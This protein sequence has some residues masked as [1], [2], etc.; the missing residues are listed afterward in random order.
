MAHVLI[1]DDE[2]ELCRLLDTLLRERG[3]D[4]ES[5]HSG[6]AAIAA[7]SERQPELVLLDMRL[8]GMD[9][10]ETLRRLR[11]HAP[12]TPIVIM[13]AFGNVQAAVEA[14]KLGATDFISKP[15][16]NLA[17]LAT[18]ETLLTMRRESR[19]QA[20]ELVGDSPAFRHT[21]SLAL[22]FAVP[23]INVLLLGET[24]TGKELFARTIHAASK[25]RAGPF[26]PVDCSMLAENLIESELFG[27]EKGAFTGATG[28][29][30]GRFE[31]AQEGTL[32]LDEIGNL[33][34]QFQ[35]KLLRVLQERRLERVGGRASI[36][37]DVRVVSATNVDMCA[38]LERGRFR[39][40]LYYRLQGMT[41][42]LPPLRERE[43]DIQAIAEHFVR[44]YAA[45]FGRN[46]QGISEAALELLERY[47]WP[48][49]VRELENSMKSAVVLATDL[50]LPEHLPPDVRHGGPQAGPV[51][52]VRAPSGDEEP[53]QLQHEVELA[54]ETAE[55]DLKAFGA[56]AAEHAERSLLQ[57]LLR[58]PRMTGTQMARLLGVDPKTL[59]TKLR[60]YGLEARLAHEG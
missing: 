4:P 23:D 60:R 35:A 31:L 48:G 45:R 51:S 58:R 3:H 29:R 59:R 52:S 21:M 32:F 46:V 12:E 28:N 40:D 42:E 39:R 47:P 13:T 53:E 18:I 49:N 27:H 56:Q 14:M 54:L 37:L 5:V 1:V 9:G 22:Q 2:R 8:G 57:A 36:C 20:P 50:V 55:I 33:P 16:N 38:T 10:M 24:G 25:R 17:L 43:G 34:V 15:F 30:I 7:A 6:E 19:A 41:I 11:M 26:V 44:L